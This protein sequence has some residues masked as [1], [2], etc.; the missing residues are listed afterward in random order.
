LTQRPTSSVGGAQSHDEFSVSPVALFVATRWELAALRRALPVDRRVEIEGVSC[1]IGQQGDRSYWLVHSGIGPEAA[2]AAANA[3]LTRQPMAL[4]ISTG[5]AGA[6]VPAAIGDVIVGN[7]VS[8]GWFDGAWNEIAHP[9]FCDAVVVSAV[10]SAVAQI[11]MTDH[12]GSVVSMSRVICRASE[13]QMISRLTGAVALDME[14][15]ALGTVAM[16]RGI[17]FVVFRTVSDLVGEDL[18]LDF[19]LFL[20]PAGWVRGLVSLLSHPSSLI[21]LNRLRRQSRLAA[22]RLAA[23]CFAYAGGGFGLLPVREAGRT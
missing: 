21:G 12:I 5:F 11:G 4:A 13:K 3:V 17:P 22:D 6:L 15:A 8:S 2:N 14:S 7:S 20:R 18:P 10:R 1:F 9:I 23:V 16:E 19:N